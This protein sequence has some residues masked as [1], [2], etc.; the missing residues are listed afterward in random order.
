MR[1]GF[2]HYVFAATAATIVS[3]AVAERCDFVAYLVYSSM[4]TGFIYPVLTHW[5]WSRNG[6]LANGMDYEGDEGMFNIAYYDFAGSGIVHMCGG[7][8]AFVGAWTM[9]PRIGR[10]D[11]E[12]GTPI[13]IKGHSVPLAAL[14]GFI[15]LFGFFAFN[16]SSQG[17][18][19]SPGDGTAVSIS[20]VNTVIAGSSGAFLTMILNKLKWIG[21]GKWSF[22][23]TL[24]GCL[25]GMVASC[26]GVSQYYTYAAFVVGL[27][28]GVFYMIF[29]WL[30][31]RLRV[32]DPL[33]A[34]AVHF[35]G[36]LWGVIAVAFMSKDFGIFYHRDR[37]SGLHLAWQL[38]GMVS[39][40]LWTGLICLIMFMTLKKIGYLRV[41]FDYELKGLDIPKHGEPAYPSEAYGHGWADKGDTLQAMVKKSFA[42]SLAAVST[43]GGPIVNAYMNTPEKMTGNP[44]VDALR[45]RQH[46]S[47]SGSTTSVA[48]DST[49][50]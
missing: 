18:I 45:K 28:G 13:D 25:T 12:T 30:V 2:F 11:K 3:G 4:V 19:S 20:V 47:A 26:S 32:D 1:S 9:G 50:L 5:A 10:F 46:Y 14:G 22:L 17:S 37:K 7:T 42:S 24:N 15:L 38:V 31:L 39:V 6:W 33:D 16:G 35:G 40:T 8:A 43:E 27:G 21:D 36:G 29:T 44:E 23:T 34:T 49:L 48:T 41:P